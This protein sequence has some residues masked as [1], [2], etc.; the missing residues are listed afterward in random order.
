M[1]F[2]FQFEQMEINLLKEL[3]H[4]NIVRYL[5]H[6]RSETK[7][8]I[9]MEYTHPHTHT[10]SLFHTLTLTLTCVLFPLTKNL[11]ITFLTNADTDEL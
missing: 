9:V 8:S 4:P 3:N 6:H 1:T 7:L 10:H 11:T 5:G 2:N